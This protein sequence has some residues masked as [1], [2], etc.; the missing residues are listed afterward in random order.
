MFLGRVHGHLSPPWS[1]GSPKADPRSLVVGTRREVGM[2]GPGKLWRSL[3]SNKH[4]ADGED[5]LSVRVSR[6]VAEAHAGET[7]EREVQGGDVG[8]A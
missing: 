3:T 8:A 7:A 5:L 6:H 2:E 4:G 1:G